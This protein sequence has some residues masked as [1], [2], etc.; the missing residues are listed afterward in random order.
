MNHFIAHWEVYS[1]VPPKHILRLTPPDE[2]RSVQD[3]I[4]RLLSRDWY[5]HLGEQR[6][7]KSRVPHFP[8]FSPVQ[9]TKP[10]ILKPVIPC[11]SSYKWGDHSINRLTGL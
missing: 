1:L 6:N 5:A 10:S 4:K 8:T 2:L 9:S 3:A 7:A 11:Y